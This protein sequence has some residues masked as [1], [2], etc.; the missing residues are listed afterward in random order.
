M[1]EHF[2]SV[3]FAEK[4]SSLNKLAQADPNALLGALEKIY[5][6]VAEKNP[7]EAK[8]LNTMAD[9]VARVRGKFT[10]EA[11]RK[12]YLDHTAIVS[13][14]VEGR[15]EY[16]VAAQVLLQLGQRLNT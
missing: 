2:D 6:R 13:A 4:S 7:G 11:A 12:V 8:G 1:N 5:R 10:A 15:K 9:E 16:G 14:R 3:K